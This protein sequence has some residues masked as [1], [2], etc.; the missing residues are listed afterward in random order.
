MSQLA[1][2]GASN[3]VPSAGAIWN[4]VRV[5]SSID[6]ALRVTTRPSKVATTSS[7]A[8]PLATTPARRGASAPRGERSTPFA[9][10]P[11]INTTPVRSPTAAVT[12]CGFVA[13]E[14]STNATPPAA[15]AA[16]RPA[17]PRVRRRDPQRATSDELS[18]HVAAL[19]RTRLA[20][21]EPTDAT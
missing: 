3:T 15:A 2:P 19:A 8:S 5:A 21:G 16:P 12:A 10:P 14:L 18:G 4:A 1:H 9:R 13:F 17:R 6:P 7:A 20:E 11:A